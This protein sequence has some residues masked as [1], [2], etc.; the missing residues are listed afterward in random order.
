MLT[1][2][3][4]TEVLKMRHISESVTGLQARAEMF[5]FSYR[6]YFRFTDY[7]FMSKLER[8]Q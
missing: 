6:K 7:V 3:S 2:F 5:S 1:R 8:L 4:Q